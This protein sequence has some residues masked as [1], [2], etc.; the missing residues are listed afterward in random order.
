M[1]RL[2]KEDGKWYLT[3]GT[4]MISAWA[5]LPEEHQITDDITV[6]EVIGELRRTKKLTP[7]EKALLKRWEESGLL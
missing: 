1:V 3:D 7:K 4:E 5:L 6:A 2:S